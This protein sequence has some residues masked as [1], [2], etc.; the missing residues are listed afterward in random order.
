[1]AKA[2]GLEFQLDAIDY[3]RP[4]W[5]N[6]DMSV[7][8]L[9][10]AL[11]GGEAGGSPEADQLFGM[12][13]GQGLGAQV[14]GLL[15]RLVGSNPQ[16]SAMARLMVIETTSSAELMMAGAKD[17][18]EPDRGAGPMAGLGRM[19]KVLI[20]D[21][22]DVVFRDLREVMDHEPEIKSVALFYGAGH[23]P[24]FE[25]RLEELGY[26]AGEEQWLTAMAVNAK[27]TGMSPESL[28][29]TRQM[30]KRM[31]NA[32]MRQMQPGR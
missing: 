12:L 30:M 10:R 19:M 25:T 17:A 7:G 31:L 27:D 14:A 20:H 3:Q 4:D 2:L 23:L 1:M 26:I 18:A 13:S 6:S 9:Q 5:R 32:Q 22:N 24:D 15:L 21:R 8:Q 28:E 29:Q 11:T 16:M